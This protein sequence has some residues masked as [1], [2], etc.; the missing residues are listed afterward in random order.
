TEAVSDFEAGIV[1]SVIIGHGK[2]ISTVNFPRNVENAGSLG[3]KIKRASLIAAISDELMEIAL[4]DY[5][6]FINYYRKHSMILGKKINY[7]E[8]GRV[9]RALALEIDEN[10]G[11]VV[12]KENGEKL[13]LRSGEISIRKI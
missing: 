5:K 6:G 10:G 12:E 11:L 4:G 8:N 1:T 7:I 9:T 13:T 3:V 2:N